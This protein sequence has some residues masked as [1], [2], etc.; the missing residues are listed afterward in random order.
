MSCIAT[1]LMEKT[2]KTFKDVVIGCL[3]SECQ[4][5]ALLVDISEM[6][7]ICLCCSSFLA[8]I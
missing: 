7:R 8:Y 3:K 6:L 1:M 2:M 5:V 4:N